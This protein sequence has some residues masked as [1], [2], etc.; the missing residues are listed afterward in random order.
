MYRTSIGGRKLPTIRRT[1]HSTHL[2]KEMEWMKESQRMEWIVVVKCSV[3][4]AIHYTGNTV[5]EKRHQ[6]IL[7]S[8]TLEI[9]LQQKIV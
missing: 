2:S 3:G 7:P 8:V 9:L 5:M 4:V 6:S 1:T